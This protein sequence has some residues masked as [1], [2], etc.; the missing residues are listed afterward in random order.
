MPSSPILIKSEP[1]SRTRREP[2]SP[3]AWAALVV[4]SVALLLV[5]I[6]D[7]GLALYPF[8]FGNPEWRFSTLASVATGL[9]MLTVGALLSLIVA[10][11]RSRRWSLAAIGL[12]ALILVLIIGAAAGFVGAAGA[13][14]ASAPPE[15]HLGLEKA[16]V[17]SIILFVVFGAAHGV[18]VVA[19]ARDLQRG[20]AV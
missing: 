15:V 17:K 13:T 7:L 20:P 10:L 19:A 4:L 2:D 12:N 6:T 14:F 18:A 8:N 5:S 3:A 9:P 11:R 16:M 1:A